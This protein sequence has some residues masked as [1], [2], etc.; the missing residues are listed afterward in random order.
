MHTS[1][2]RLRVGWLPVF[3]LGILFLSLTSCKKDEEQVTVDYSARDEEAIKAYIAENKLTGF[4]RDSTGVYI[5]I[6]Q[7]GTGATAV[8][9][10][11]V[12]TKYVGTTLDGTVFDK[13]NPAAIGFQFV[14][15]V[16]DV[17]KGWDRG[18]TYLNKGSKAILLIPSGQA[19]AEQ[20]AGSIPP[21]SILRFDVEVVDI[22]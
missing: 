15:G 6:T 3:L 8:K 14:L 7:P 22:K 13:S 4:Q 17:I 16:G 1:F 11:K 21:N 20:V 18:F 5:I 2:F 12:T 19:Y 10:Q 9:K